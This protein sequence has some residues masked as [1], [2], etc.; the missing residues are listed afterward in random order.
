MLKAERKELIAVFLPEIRSKE[1]LVRLVDELGFL[2]YFKGEIPGFSIEENC[3]CLWGTPENPDCPWDW[4]GPV[5]RESGCAYGK[6]YHGRALY[7]SRDWFPDFAN[8]RRDGYDY[9]ARV[10]DGKARHKDERIMQILT[11]RSPLVS[12]EL[13]A[14]ACLSEESRKGFD[15][16]MVFLQ[17]QGYVTVSDFVYQTDRHGKPFGW[18]LAQYATPEQ[19]F[20]ADFTARVYTRE[21]SE[22]AA[23]IRAHL[24]KLLPQATPAQIARFLG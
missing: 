12:K 22:S 15:A 5:I 21:P 7:I 9:D 6:F 8:H 16:C 20:G 2:P 14:L 11:E 23:R 13:R 1:D 24:T 3:R 18:G 17:M 4:K 10:D 19:R